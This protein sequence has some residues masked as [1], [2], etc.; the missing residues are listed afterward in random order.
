[1][2]YVVPK[3]V[4]KENHDGWKLGRSEHH[5]CRGKKI[6]IEP[7]L[8]DIYCWN[9]QKNVQSVCMME[10]HVV[11]GCLDYSLLKMLS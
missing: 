1:M 7:L 3:V 5:Y 9:R 10:E 4:D 2:P 8:H 11:D 6:H